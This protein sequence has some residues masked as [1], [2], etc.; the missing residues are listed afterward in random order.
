MYDSPIAQGL[1]SPWLPDM[2]DFSL[3]SN[4]AAGMSHHDMGMSAPSPGWQM[5]QPS[6]P[7]P[8]TPASPQ[9]HIERP[10][11]MSYALCDSPSGLLSYI[12]D[13][14]KPPTVRPATAQPSPSPRPSPRAR[15]SPQDQ[16]IQQFPRPYTKTAIVNWVMMHW[17][18]GPEVALR[19]VANSAAMSASL[20]T[21]YSMVPL[22]ISHYSP[23]SPPGTPDMAQASL[24]WAE[25]YH[26]VIMVR[27]RQ[28]VV[29]FAAWERPAEV[30][31][32]LR[33]MVKLVFQPAP[34]PVPMTMAMH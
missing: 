8:T 24:P 10:Q 17:I 27:R 18:P 12:L 22:G 7:R 25:A 2:A 9:S 4:A 34:T 32:D 33:E 26:H 5:Q 16:E 21:N 15:N 28:G 31:M 11:T 30:V 20:W 3:C 19:W 1:S 23:Q 6:S 29:N 13:L 14:I